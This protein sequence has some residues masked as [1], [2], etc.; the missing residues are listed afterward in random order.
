MKKGINIIEKINEPMLPATVFFGL[1]LVSLMPL[2]NLPKVKPPIS[3][4]I[5]T[6]I[7]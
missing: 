3:D 4:I 1:I 6:D 5:D 2:K 7:E